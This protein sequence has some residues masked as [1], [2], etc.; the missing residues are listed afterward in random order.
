MLLNFMAGGS[1]I[2]LKAAHLQNLYH[3][4]QIQMVGD[5]NAFEFYGRWLLIV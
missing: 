4:E 5:K 2:L 3:C 1:Y